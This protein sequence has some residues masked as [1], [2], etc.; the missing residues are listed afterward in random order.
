MRKQEKP[1]KAGGKQGPSVPSEDPSAAAGSGQLRLQLTGGWKQHF[2]RFRLLHFQPLAFSCFNVTPAR[3]FADLLTG[4]EDL[5][6]V[7][8]F[9][10]GRQAVGGGAS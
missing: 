4:A 2:L 8:L 10:G 1:Q 7:G 5:R 3:V 6:G 9:D